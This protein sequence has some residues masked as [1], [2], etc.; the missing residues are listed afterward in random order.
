AVVNH[1]YTAR[2][3]APAA[4]VQHRVG[5]VSNVAH[6]SFDGALVVKTLG[7]EGAEVA[8]MSEASDHLRDAR[9]EVGR[10]RAAF[11]PTIDAIPSIGTVGLILV[12]AWRLSDGAV[13]PGDL[14]TAM[15]LFGVLAFPMRVVGFFLEELPK[16]V[17]SA[18]RIDGVLAD[19]P[20][21]AAEPAATSGE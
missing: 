10:L 4:M 9:I 12:G 1:V 18:D 7:R 14:V 21:P 16:S 19:R 5:E 17:V 8:R 15:A 11:E 3:E 20:A 2:V 13:S 6:E